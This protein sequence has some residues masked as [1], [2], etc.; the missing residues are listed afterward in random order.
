MSYRFDRTIEEGI[1]LYRPNTVD[2]IFVNRTTG[3]STFVFRDS[4][5]GIRTTIARFYNNHQSFN[6]PLLL[7]YSFD[8]NKLG[9][10]VFTGPNLKLL[11]TTSG[12]TATNNP[13]FIQLERTDEVYKTGLTLDWTL[14]GQIN[15]RLSDR[16]S[17]NL[18]GGLEKS[19]S[20]WIK[21]EEF[22]FAKRPLIF[23]LNVGISF[24]L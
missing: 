1:Q 18:N 4:I 9:F 3:D 12:L 20:N 16:F 2:T 21:S 7:G 24:I 6:L 5:N 19:L 23:D 10:E 8:Q 13:E 17:L 22:R 14:E 11:R 15:Y